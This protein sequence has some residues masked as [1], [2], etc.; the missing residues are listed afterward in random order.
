MG[1][2]IFTRTTIRKFT[3]EKVSEEHI[4][5]LMKAAMAAP[6]AGNQQPW[7]FILTRD[8]AVKDAL[9][10][11]SPFAKPAAAAELVIVAC[12]SKGD[13][14]RFPQYIPQDMGACVEN[15]LIEAAALGLGAAWLGIYPERDRMDAVAKCVDIPEGF[16]AF[17]IIALGHPGEEF[18]PRSEK[19]YE[20]DRVH[21]A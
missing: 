11:C 21:W 9:A 10:Q 17:A 13:D 19:R 2:P 7:E 16:E 14:L 1:D 8:A 20:P 12:M 3:D 6:S 4:E 15:I 18:P 5:L